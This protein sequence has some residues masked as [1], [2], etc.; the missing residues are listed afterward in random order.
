MDRTAVHPEA[1]SQ[2]LS[3]LCG[4]S[5]PSTF[6]GFQEAQ[7]RGAQH[8]TPQQGW[9]YLPL[10]HPDLPGISG[11]IP[12]SHPSPTPY[13]QIR[14]CGVRDSAGK[15]GVELRE[16]QSPLPSLLTFEK[17]KIRRKVNVT[18][19]FSWGSR[20]RKADPGFRLFQVW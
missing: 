18:L 7:R 5:S 2:T 16:E 13:K 14:R 8:S 19:L 6:P 10:S 4:F 12:H 11:G 20:K 3:S 9:P 15:A 17:D 1:K